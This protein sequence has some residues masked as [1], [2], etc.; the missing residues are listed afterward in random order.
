[1]DNGRPAAFARAR[2]A[3]PNPAYRAA[4]PGTVGGPRRSARRRRRRLRSRR[5]HG[6]I[7]VGH[8]SEESCADSEPTR[9]RAD[10]RAPGPDRVD[11]RDGDVGNPTLS[12]V[13]AHDGAGS[14]MRLDLD[15]HGQS[16]PRRVVAVR[17]GSV[18]LGSSLAVRRPVD[19]FT[20]GGASHGSVTL[21]PPCGFL[22]IVSSNLTAAAASP[23]RPSSPS[24]A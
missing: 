7:R 17:P 24:E 23:R 22:T 18:S 1:M 9:Q 2:R 21:R 12:C 11:H 6:A 4:L 10:E 19:P 14:A 5:R 8:R 15:R 3:A 16:L 13:V 20:L